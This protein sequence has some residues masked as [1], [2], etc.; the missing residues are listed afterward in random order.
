MRSLTL[1]LAVLFVATACVNLEKNTRVPDGYDTGW[2]RVE[3]NPLGM[4]ATVRVYQ[5]GYKGRN[6]L[7]G[8]AKGSTFSKTLLE[9]DSLTGVQEYEIRIGNVNEKT[10]IP[11]KNNHITPVH[12]DLE[13]LSTTK[14]I[15]TVS[16]GYGMVCEEKTT[17][18]TIAIDVREPVAK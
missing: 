6:E 5:V 11:V 14:K 18:F 10:R 1:S 16:C 3:V 2:V 17:R 9:F 8:E 13:H 15:N 4:D 12:I 7:I